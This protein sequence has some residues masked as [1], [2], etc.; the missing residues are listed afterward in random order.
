MKNRTIRICLHDY[1]PSYHVFK[2]GKKDYRYIVNRVFQ[3]TSD[4]SPI[5]FY[6]GSKKDLYLLIIG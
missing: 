1:L 4:I 6:I 3:D 2:K 5:T